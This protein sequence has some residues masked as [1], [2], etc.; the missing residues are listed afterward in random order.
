MMTVKSRWVSQLAVNRPNSRDPSEASAFHHFFIGLS[1]LARLRERWMN[2]LGW[3]LLQ[4]S[5][6]RVRL[7][8]DTHLMNQKICHGSVGPV[9]LCESTRGGG[10]TGSGINELSNIRLSWSRVDS[11]S[12]SGCTSA[13]LLSAQLT[14]LDKRSG[15]RGVFLPFS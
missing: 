4:E 3:K 8:P 5:T 15:R 2:R 12:L 10:A 6:Q 14:F 9:R 13:L 11:V 7:M 1:F